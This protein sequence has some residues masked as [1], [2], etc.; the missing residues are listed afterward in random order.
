MREEIFILNMSI[1]LF[2]VTRY[3]FLSYCN[4]KLKHNNSTSVSKSSFLCT[5]AVTW[6]LFFFHFQ[7]FQ[8]FFLPKK[9]TWAM[10]HDIKAARDCFRSRLC[11]HTTAMLTYFL[12]PTDGVRKKEGCIS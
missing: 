5:K 12:F 3:E 6:E 10:N 1:H 2:Y 8:F 4:T 7:K 9:E 11:C